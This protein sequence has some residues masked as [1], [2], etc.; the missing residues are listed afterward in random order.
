MIYFVTGKDRA[1]TQKTTHDLVAA[2]QKKRPNALVFRMSAEEWN[3]DEF[4][5]IATGQGL[6]EHKYI[7]VLDSLFEREDSAEYLEDK[8]DEL[9]KTDHAFLFVEYAPKAAPKKLITTYAEKTWEVSEGPVA[10]KQNF[11]IFSLTDALGERNRS[12]LWSLY[13]RALMEGSELEEIHGIL[14]WQIKSLLAAAQS[15]TADAAGLKPFVW[16]KSQK[17]LKNYTL[18]ELKKMSSDMMNLYH[19]SR[20]ESRSLESSLEE[21]LLSSVA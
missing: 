12:R 14:F 7:V 19:L 20:L 2:L 17:F 11:N 15:K 1:K 13:Q 18:P 6:F 21:F 9:K 5:G 16:S 3:K 4:D 10:L 8:M